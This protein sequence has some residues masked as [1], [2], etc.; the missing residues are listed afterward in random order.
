MTLL[1]AIK[2]DP[3][4]LTYLTIYFVNL[5][6]TM[7]LSIIMQRPRCLDF[8]QC[9]PASLFPAGRTTLAAIEPIHLDQ[10]AA[11]LVRH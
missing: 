11:L 7:I 3:Q 2:R 5:M 6:I 9:S 4:T 1:T 8:T 10:L